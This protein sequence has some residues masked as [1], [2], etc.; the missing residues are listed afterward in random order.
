MSKLIKSSNKKIYIMNLQHT[1]FRFL[2]FLLLI[3]LIVKKRGKL[4]FVLNNFTLFLQ[5]KIKASRH[6][7][8]SSNYKGGLLTNY[9][10]VFRAVPTFYKNNKR[11][12][13]FL[14]PSAVITNPN[15]QLLK[16]LKLTR[17]PG[18]FLADSSSNVYL[19]SYGISGNASSFA[20]KTLVE[21]SLIF[22]TKGRLAEKLQFKKSFLY[23]KKKNKYPTFLLNSKNLFFYINNLKS[24]FFL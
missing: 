8:I 10:Y 22:A 23:L 9:S 24:Y 17:T 21:A 4:L 7:I 18:A 19:A 13:T 6:S 11:R 1:L 12:N 3:E 15:I 16:E 20:F 14:F 2:K 5:T